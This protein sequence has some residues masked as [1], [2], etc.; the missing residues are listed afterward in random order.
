MAIHINSKNLSEEDTKRLEITPAITDRGW[1]AR[2]QIR[3]EYSF[4]NGRI[5]VKNKEIRKG[6]RKKDGE[7]GP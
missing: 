3:M 5:M 6:K 7:R 1:D 4:T 2:K